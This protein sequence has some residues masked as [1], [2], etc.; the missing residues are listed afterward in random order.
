MPLPA[1]GSGHAATWQTMAVVWALA[2][3]GWDFSRRRIPNVLTFGVI[4]V[5]IGKLAMTGT[6]PLGADGLSMLAGAAFALLLTLPG[7][8]AH[9]LGAGDVKL[10]VAIALL[11]GT[12]S[13]LASFMIGALAAG[14]A[15]GAWLA[16]GPRLG[17]PPAAGRR[18]PFGAALALGF[19]A[20]VA[21]GQAGDLPWPR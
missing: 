3:G 16:L 21:G 9:K 2:V 12:L 4:P 11:G 13:V 7:Y 19:V 18:L 20:A 6:S 14:V 1:V 17:L 15:A 5:A 8:L 10:L